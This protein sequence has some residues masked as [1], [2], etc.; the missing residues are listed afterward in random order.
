[1]LPLV[2][3]ELLFV[4]D[5]CRQDTSRTGL[6]P[7]D[8]INVC[9]FWKRWPCQESLEQSL[10]GPSGIKGQPSRSVRVLTFCAMYWESHECGER[11]PAVLRLVMAECSVPGGFEGVI[12]PCAFEVTGMGLLFYKKMQ[13]ILSTLSAGPVGSASAGDCVDV[14]LCDHKWVLHVLCG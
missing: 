7:A 11:P 13:C 3:N 10:T 4:L 6:S 9:T 2:C 1:M 5:S 8:M 14:L 12:D